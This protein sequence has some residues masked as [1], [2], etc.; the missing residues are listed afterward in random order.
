MLLTFS[1][2]WYASN[3]SSEGIHFMYAYA[4]VYFHLQK[5]AFEFRIYFKRCLWIG[6][7]WIEQPPATTSNHQQPPTTQ[8]KHTN[9]QC[10]CIVHCISH[11]YTFPFS[12]RRLCFFILPLFGFGRRKKYFKLNCSLSFSVFVNSYFV[13]F[14]TIL[15][16]Y[17]WLPVLFHLLQTFTVCIKL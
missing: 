6:V 7:I 13:P 5:S 1:Y 9:C 16:L 15:S 17:L 2:H 4:K 3:V 11:L 8:Q 12:F 14:S 10:M